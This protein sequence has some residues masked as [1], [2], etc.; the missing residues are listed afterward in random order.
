MRLYVASQPAFKHT[1]TTPSV[2]AH[3]S[4][5][6]QHHQCVKRMSRGPLPQTEWTTHIY[7]PILISSAIFSA[8]MYTVPIGN[9]GGKNGNTDASTTLKFFVPYTLALESTTAL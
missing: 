7:R 2:I 3:D 4:S 5:N 9:P 8:T 6:P 1:T